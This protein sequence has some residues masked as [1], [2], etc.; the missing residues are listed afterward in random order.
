M[1]SKLIKTSNN[2]TKFLSLIGELE[3]SGK[4]PSYGQF[5]ELY[6]CAYN[7]GYK[8]GHD[9]GYKVGLAVGKYSKWL[10]AHEE[11]NP[12]DN[13][14]N[15]NCHSCKYDK[16][17]DELHLPCCLCRAGSQWESADEEQN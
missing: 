12:M 9:D 11:D 14:K 4:F 2:K 8:R 17:Y 7:E 3:E 10:E 6:D 5:L 1:I 13:T 16:V 15:R